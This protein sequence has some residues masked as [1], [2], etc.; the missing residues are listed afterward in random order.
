MP[1][2]FFK[3]FALKRHHLHSQ[4]YL[5]PFRALMHHPVYWGISRRNTVPAFALGIFIAFIPFPAHTMTAVVLA[6]ILRLNIPVAV[7]TTLLSNPLTMGPIFYFSY[8]LG[9]LLLGMEP[10]HFQIEL[11]FDW[12]N[13]GFKNTWQPLML[14]S[15]LA[16]SLAALTSYIVLDILWR[17]SLSDYLKK[18]RKRRG[19]NSKQDL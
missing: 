5:R 13:T 12:L 19:I 18:R 8:R 11:T 7:A 1:R 9:L 10:Q 14:G 17:A 2:R 4:W 3:K 6:L 16:G 15:F